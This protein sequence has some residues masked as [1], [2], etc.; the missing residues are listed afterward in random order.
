[1]C[2]YSMDKAIDKS[3]DLHCGYILILLC[4][5][6]AGIL[7]LLCSLSQALEAPIL[8]N[9]HKY[10]GMRSIKFLF[11]LFS[12][13]PP[14]IDFFPFFY[15][16]VSFAVPSSPHCST[17]TCAILSQTDI[18][19]T[20]ALQYFFKFMSHLLEPMQVYPLLVHF[21][22]VHP[23][24]LQVCMFSRLRWCLGHFFVDLKDLPFRYF[25]S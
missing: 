17:S 25:Y 18:S 9:R 5:T 24:H 10:W 11:T 22:H 15:I 1:M 23:L 14:C 19:P 21:H 13:I 4:G 16:L 7:S 3:D 8:S 20:L 2:D 12:P 6:L